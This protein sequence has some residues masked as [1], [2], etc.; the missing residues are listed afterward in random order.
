MITAK[1]CQRTQT[2]TNTEGAGGG[3][4]RQAAP[5]HTGVA[6]TCPADKVTNDRGSE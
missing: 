4:E 6:W 2:G 3:T 1:T 5:T